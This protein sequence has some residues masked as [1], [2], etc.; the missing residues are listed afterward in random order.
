MT[1]PGVLA[2][3]PSSVPAGSVTT[4]SNERVAVFMPAAESATVTRT[5]RGPESAG[6]ATVTVVFPPAEPS[7]PTLRRAGLT[8]APGAVT[9][10]AAPFAVAPNA[11]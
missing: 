9:R 8:D 2:G 11:Q 3:L 10:T 5:A 6:T 7:V 4:R 1:P